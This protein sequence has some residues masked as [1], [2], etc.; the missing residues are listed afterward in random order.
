MLKRFVQAMVLAA[1]AAVLTACTVPNSGGADL[2]E[3]SRAAYSHDGPPSITLYTMLS[4][5]NGA[6]AH[7][8]ILVNGSQRV[9]FDPA[10]SFRHEK[11]VSRNDT[12]FGMTPYLVDQY[13]RFHAR[14]TYHVV[15]QTIEV[16]PEVAEQALQMVVNHPAVMQSHC[17]MS[18]SR[19]LSKLPGFEDV[20]PSY[21]PKRLMETFADK[22]A[23]F[24]RLYEYD[25]DD[26]TGVLRAFVPEYE[27]TAGL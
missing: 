11:I 19:L 3:V 5:R 25:E 17:A 6:G 20:K 12:V 24:E 26:K 1:S 8:S 2:E 27:R 4:N 7:T 15:I 18:T 10:G 9:A 14:E 21:Y 13:T 22:G 16:S 23:T